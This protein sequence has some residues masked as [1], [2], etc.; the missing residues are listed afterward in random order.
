MPE[1]LVQFDEPFVFGR[2][3]RFV[4][5]VCGRDAGGK[6]E[7][8]IEFIPYLG[9]DVFRTRRETEQL[10]RSDLK[11]WAAG[12]SRSM[13]QERL[14]LLVSRRRDHVGKPPRSY[15]SPLRG[16]EGKL[17]E[18]HSVDEG[19][20]FVYGDPMDLIMEGEEILRDYLG[21]LGAAE[22]VS[23]S[24]MYDL[25]PLDPFDDEVSFEEALINQIVEAARNYAAQRLP[26][27]PESTGFLKVLPS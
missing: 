10:S 1:I 3:E 20:Y 22:L 17:I 12:L 13:I 7:G 4:A 27:L 9:G 8:W 26:P 16:D 18:R 23:Y 6:W 24:V 15:N 25:P 14:Y 2:W 19:D 11:Y 21:S 5:R